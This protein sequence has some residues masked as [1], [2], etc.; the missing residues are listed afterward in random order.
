MGTGDGAPR[1]ALVVLTGAIRV[2]RRVPLGTGDG[3]PRGALVV[4]TGAIRVGRRIL[5]DQLEAIELKSADVGGRRQLT[6][7]YRH[8]I[9]SGSSLLYVRGVVNRLIDA[10]TGWNGQ[11][12][13]VSG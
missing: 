9:R 13:P 6:E 2:G 1:G 10:V 8:G 4:L 7:G 11:S 5:L 12:I 3:A